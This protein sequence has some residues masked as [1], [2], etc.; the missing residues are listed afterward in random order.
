E[1]G[2]FGRILEI[3][4]QR[5]LDSRSDPLTAVLA[6]HASFEAG[7]PEVARALAS[8]LAESPTSA[9]R[10]RAQIVLA[11][12]LRASGQVTEATRLHQASIRSAEETD[13]E[14][15]KAWAGVH[16]FRHLTISAPRNV[17]AAMLPSV[18]AQVLGSGSPRAAAYLHATVAV[19]EGQAGRFLEAKRH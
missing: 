7:A 14:E 8:A 5:Q 17:A 13:D 16:L 15:L 18:R 10:A 12:C 2:E 6:A 3:S 1:A 19:S 4:R 9:I 11:L